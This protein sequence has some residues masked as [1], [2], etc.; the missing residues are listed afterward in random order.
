MT[1]TSTESLKSEGFALDRYAAKYGIKRVELF[2][3]VESDEELRQRIV[4]K[5]STQKIEFIY[6]DKSYDGY[7]VAVD[8]VGDFIVN[9]CS[10]RFCHMELFLY[11]TFS[12]EEVRLIKSISPHAYMIWIVRS[13]LDDPD[14][15]V[16]TDENTRE[17]L[18]KLEK[19]KILLNSKN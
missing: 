18:F 19:G 4:D 16:K 13:D 8:E 14:S 9:C 1:E 7:V 10:D 3:T 15:L 5:M 2:L 11:S 17:W 6:C 12:V